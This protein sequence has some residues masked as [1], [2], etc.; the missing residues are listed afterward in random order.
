M[1]TVACVRVGTKYGPDH[2]ARLAS[3]VRRHLRVPHRIICLTDQRATVPGVEVVDIRATGLW[4]WW[5]KMALFCPDYRGHLPTIYLDLDTVILRDIT[6]LARVAGKFA[7]SRNMTRLAGNTTW[8]CLYGSHCMVFGPGWG[9]QVWNAFE[10]DRRGLIARAGIMGDQWV[11]QQLV[12]DAPLLQDMLPPGFI[13][14]YRDIGAEP[15]EQAAIVAFGG[16]SKPEGSRVG[17][18]QA[19]WQ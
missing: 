14:G 7:I 9:R 1:H 13:M 17:W 5:G 2:V 19:A 18:V 3:M 15:P 11:I 4:G 6:P 10:A 8:P 12:P 16:R